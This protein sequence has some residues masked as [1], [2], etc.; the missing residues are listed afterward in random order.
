MR[1]PMILL[2]QMA[3]T[4]TQEPLVFTL[5]SLAVTLLLAYLYHRIYEFFASLLAR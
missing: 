5:I 1:I 3:V 2:R 4:W